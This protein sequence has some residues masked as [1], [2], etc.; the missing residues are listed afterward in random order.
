[1]VKRNQ[2]WGNELSVFIAFFLTQRKYGHGW[3][4][5]Y[6]TLKTLLSLTG[7]VG[8]P[9]NSWMQDINYAV[10]FYIIYI[11]IIFVFKRM[12]KNREKLHF[13]WLPLCFIFFC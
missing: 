5:P 8:E 10:F 4:S 7:D 13:I 9:Y 11:T 2:E 12:Y 1:M 6:E 3:H